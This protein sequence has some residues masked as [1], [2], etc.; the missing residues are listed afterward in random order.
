LYNS[1]DKRKKELQLSK[2]SRLCNLRAIVQVFVVQSKVSKC[3]T[4]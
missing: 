3:K 2:I 4:A 1:Q